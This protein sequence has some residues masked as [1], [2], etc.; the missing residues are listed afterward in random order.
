MEHA[1]CDKQYH[2][3]SPS[4]NKLLFHLSTVH[5]YPLT[6]GGR[7]NNALRSWQDFL[8]A[9]FVACYLNKNEIGD[10]ANSVGATLPSPPSKTLSHEVPPATSGRSMKEEVLQIEHRAKFPA[11]ARIWTSRSAYYN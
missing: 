1:Y 7:G 10:A 2:N 9:D 5:Q 3:T 6:S 11:W 8:C 4:L